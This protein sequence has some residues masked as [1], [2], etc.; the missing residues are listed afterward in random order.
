MIT[1]FSDVQFTRR[2]ALFAGGLGTIGLSLPQL[3]HA[4]N[5]T[6]TRTEKSIILVVPWGGPSQH[7]TLDPKP[8]APAEVR[9]LHGDIAT[10]TVGMRLGSHLSRLAAMSDRFSVLRAVSHQIGAHNPAT[11]LAFTGYPPRIVNENTRATRADYPAIGSAL[12]KVLPS[13]EDLPSY[14][15]LPL[16]MIDNGNFS[17]GQN[18]GFLG[19]AYDPLVVLSDR[20]S[21]NFSVVGATP[22]SDVGPD[23]SEDRRDLLRQLDSHATRMADAPAVRDM[24]VCYTRA[25]DLLRS[26]ASSQAFDISR[27]PTRVR[28]R[29]GRGI[30]QSVLAAR[31]LVEAGVRLVLVADTSENTNGKWDTHGDDGRKIPL[32]LRESDQAVSALF[33]DLQARG[34]LDTTIV[35]WMAEFGRTPR[36]KPGGGRDHWPA[37]YSVLLGGGGIRGGRAIGASDSLGAQPRDG[38]VRPEDILA[39]FYSLLG[40]PLHTEIHDPTGRPHRLCQGSVIQALL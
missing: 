38:R 22:P 6:R 18:A 20:R 12:A 16:P 32:H 3:L 10:R 36:L 4:E 25:Y 33:E 39:T 26:A 14:V 13:R 19:T 9:S 21:G 23:R 35:A 5:R 34:L 30:G 7:D 31:R 2:Q 1:E 37:V 15:Q 29:Y 24:S 11:H 17:N 40:V 8:D 28:D 27:E